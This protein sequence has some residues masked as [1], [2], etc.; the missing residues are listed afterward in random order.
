[1][2]GTLITVWLIGDADA[3][4]L[5]ALADALGGQG[6]RVEL[7]ARDRAHGLAETADAHNVALPNLIVVAADLAFAEDHRILGL[8][9]GST[10]WTWLPV[11]VAARADDEVRRAATYD[12]GAA[13]WIVVPPEPDARR[14]VADVFARY[15]ARACIVPDT[16]YFRR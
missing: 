16:S 2:P 15:W 5:G 10:P 7:I 13:A 14:E 6:C 12:A 9:T 11:V 1:M 3:D 4:G 8:L